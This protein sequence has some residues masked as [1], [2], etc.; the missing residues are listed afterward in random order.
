MFVRSVI[1]ADRV[2][3]AMDFP[4][5]F[6]PE[7]FLGGLFR[8]DVDLEVYAD[9][10]GGSDETAFAPVGYITIGQKWYTSSCDGSAFAIVMAETNP[11]AES[12]H[13][14]ASMIIVPTDTPGYDGGA[15]FS[16]DCSQ[17]V[18]RASR[19]QPGEELQDYQGLLAED[20]VRPSKLEI[21]VADA[22]GGNVR[23][24]TNL[25]AASFAPFFFP[26]GDR[27]LFS[28]NHGDASGREFDI[29]AIDVDGSA[30][31][32][33]T[34]HPADEFTPSWSRDGRTLYFQNEGLFAVS[35]DWQET[36]V[37]SQ[38]RLISA[39][40]YE[41]AIAGNSVWATGDWNGD[42]DFTS[43]DMVTA[44]ADGGYEA[45][46]RPAVAAVPEP[47]AFAL[48]MIALALAGVSSSRQR[49]LRS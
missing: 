43:S 10:Y 11:E 47:S 46:R 25:G 8:F 49:G 35:I 6:V 15:F 39:G 42:G 1:G 38:P 36:P 9:G 40:E 28:T 32:K 7:D 17:I 4:Y 13:R 45:G 20:K 30:L 12:H 27:V 26:S 34:S 2:M 21:F 19:P 31:R 16:A 22:D 3:Y 24:V 29:W 48:M 5:Q 44:F 41:D 18:W 37:L 14:K 23:Q 33:V